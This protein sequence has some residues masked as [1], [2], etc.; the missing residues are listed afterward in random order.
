MQNSSEMNQDKVISLFGKKAE[1]KEDKTKEE[2][3]DEGLSFA[4]IMRRNAENADRLKKERAKANQGVI[5]SYR[6]K[7]R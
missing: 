7:P 5:K 3:K 1:K 6:L 4:E 2:T